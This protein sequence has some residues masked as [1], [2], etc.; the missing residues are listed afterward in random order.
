[1]QWSG[2]ELDSEYYLDDGYCLNKLTH[3]INSC[4]IPWWL[5]VWKLP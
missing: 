2:T 4:E 1:M 5:Q 3:E